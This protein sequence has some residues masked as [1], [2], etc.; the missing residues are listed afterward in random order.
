MLS[1]I[2]GR[3]QLNSGLVQVAE[4][5]TLNAFDITGYDSCFASLAFKIHV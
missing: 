2:V 3:R 1:V 4:V 5:V